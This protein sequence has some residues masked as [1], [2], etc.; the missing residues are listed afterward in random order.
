[1]QDLSAVFA[2]SR[3]FRGASQDTLA[4]LVRRARTDSVKRGFMLVA[5]GDPADRF[6]VV[7]AGKVRVFHQTPD[8]RRFVFEDIAA[9]DAFGVPA[10][11]SGGRYPASVEAATPA[12]IA[13]LAR[14]AFFDALE[15]EPALV[16]ALVS[17]LSRRI[18]NLTSVAQTLAM[19]VPARLAGYLFQRA[20]AAG[21][22]TE[23]GLVVD[24]GMTKTE[25]A[26]ALGTVP[27]TLSRAFARLREDGVIRV[28]GA[29][30][31]VFDVGALAR[32]S[33]GYKE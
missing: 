26:E 19:D 25:L 16:R 15:A 17:D 1:M 18:V 8:G 23:N 10:A 24:L 33:A 27:E 14:D 30:I 13:W 7:A 12:T 21:R 20:L 28:E 4:E 31:R 2:S 9:P 6:G 3:L 22:P 29:E 5:E 32:M 11:L